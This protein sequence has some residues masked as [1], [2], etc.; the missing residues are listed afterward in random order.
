MHGRPRVAKGAKVDS[1]KQEEAKKKASLYAQLQAGVLKS[2]QE[3]SYGEDD[4]RRCVRLL[5]LNPDVYT[6]WNYRKLA[7]RHLAA[8]AADAAAKQVLVDTELRLVIAALKR[9]PKAYGAWYHRKWVLA[10]G[11]T[12]GAAAAEQELRL[13]RHLLQLDPRNF[14]AWDYRRFVVSLQ[15]A[16]TSGESH[17]PASHLAGTGGAAAPLQRLQEQELRQELEFTDEKI[18]ENFSN[19]S[20]WHYRSSLLTERLQRDTSEASRCRQ[21]AD[22][23]ELVRQAFF[24]APSDQ[25]AWLYYTWLLAQ[26]LP[27]PAP[28]PA[29]NPSPSPNPSALRQLASAALA[30]PPAMLAPPEKTRGELQEEHKEGGEEQEEGG[31]DITAGSA[32]TAAG[33]AGEQ[34]TMMGGTVANGAWVGDDSADGGWRAGGGAAAGAH[35]G[36]GSA[37]RE[38]E[39]GSGSGKESE[40]VRAWRVALLEDEV[41]SCRELLDLEPDRW[42]WAWEE[43]K[44]GG[45]EQEEGG[46]DITAG[47]AAT[48]AGTAGEQSTMMGGT[49]ANGAWVG[50]DSADGGW[51]AGGG[52]AAGAHQGAGSAGRESEGGSGS[53]KESETVRAWRVALL[54][55]EVASC[56]ELLDLEPDSASEVGRHLSEVRD[57]YAKLES[58][59]P[60]HAGYYRDL[61]DQIYRSS[62]EVGSRREELDRGCASRGISMRATLTTGGANKG[63]K[64]AAAKPSPH[65]V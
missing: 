33:T 18:N 36:A 38:S 60:A 20:A 35:Q 17:P 62:T 49:V 41:A 15:G 16:A 29:P 44:E 59:D 64:S 22:E 34:S 40:T 56:R 3:K 8:Q 23:F 61:M 42:V 10:L 2:H 55:D 25:S 9:N 28:S 53:G 31:G 12:G 43:H 47:S 30:G 4:M 19:Y 5:E 58:L 50:D 6:A 57:I 63:I 37:G 14:H 32:A 27:S 48:A 51:R 52:A 46:G 1:H 39:G 45:E 65:P 54:E 21:L 13:L 24:T 11:L 26:A 7:V